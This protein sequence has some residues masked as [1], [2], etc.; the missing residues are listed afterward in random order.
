MAIV[1]VILLLLAFLCFVLAAAQAPIP[2]LNLVAAGLAL[3]VLTALL[4]HLHA[5]P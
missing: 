3:W 5:A 1:S 4:P 2:R